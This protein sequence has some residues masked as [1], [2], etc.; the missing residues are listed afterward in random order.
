MDIKRL[1]YFTVLAQTGNFTK[2]ADQLGIA[3]SA[4]S[5]SIQKLE[6]QLELKLINRTERQMSLTADGQVLLRHA[7]KILEDVDQAKKELQ[8][9]KGLDSGVINFGVSAMLGSYY[10]PDTLALFKQTYPG[11]QINIQEAGTATLEKMLLD[12]QLDLALIRSDRSHDQIRHVT[13]AKEQIVACVPSTHPFAVKG[14]ITLEQFCQQPLVLF[15]DGYFL[16]EA[17]SRYCQQQKITPDIRFETNLIELLKSLVRKE[18]GIC[19]CLPII[20]GNETDL[21]TVPFEPPIPLHLGIGWKSS[22]YL[23]SAAR[24]FVSFLQTE[25]NAPTGNV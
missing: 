9:L 15:R 18:I 5:I 16:R 13:L 23:S 17:V 3:Q 10:L 19:T 2:A 8:E 24:A 6:Q 21:V 14:S 22:H 11:I 20:L 7:R 25:L 1:H 12:G 4:L